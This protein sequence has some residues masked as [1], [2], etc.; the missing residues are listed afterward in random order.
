MRLPRRRK[1]NKAN[2]KERRNMIHAERA[3]RPK[4]VAHGMV[5]TVHAGEVAISGTRV[6]SSIG[7][8]MSSRERLAAQLRHGLGTFLSSPYYR[9]APRNVRCEFNVP[10]ISAVW[11]ASPSSSRQMAMRVSREARKPR[12]R[13]L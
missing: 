13:N 5:P 4:L 7:S 9:G 12:A 3:F 10:S 8:E 2:I 1:E 6:P 11:L